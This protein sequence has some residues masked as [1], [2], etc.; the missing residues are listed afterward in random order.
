M[1]IYFLLIKIFVFTLSLSNAAYSQ[2]KQP[3]D[4]DGYDDYDYLWKDEK[5]PKDTSNIDD[6]SDF[7][8][9]LSFS[10]QSAINGGLTYTN[11]NGGNYVGMVLNPELTFG[12][13]GVGLNIPLLY[14]I[15]NK[16]FRSEIFEDGVGPLRLVTYVRY[17][18][19][20]RDP[21]FIKMGQLDNV[22]IGYGGLV[23]NYTNS[24]SVE[25]RKIGI[26]TDVNF[27]QGLVGL[28]AMYSDLEITSRNLLALRPYIRPLITTS[29]PVV[30]KLEIGGVF[31]T[32]A[33]QTSPFSDA[34]SYLYTEDGI[35]AWGIDAG[36]PVLQSDFIRV[37]L[38]A[39]YSKL[40]VADGG[41]R[42]DDDYDLTEY[43]N[44]DGWTCGTNL[45]LNFI[46]NV[47]Q[48][49]VRIERLF[50]SNNYIPQFFNTSYELN[51]DDRILETLFATKKA[52]I[53]GSLTGHILHKIRLGG[54]LLLPDDIGTDATA[55]VQLNASID[56]FMNKYSLS[57]L[58]LKGQLTDLDEAFKLDDRS[59][60]KVRAA[61]HINRFLVLGM[62]YYWTFTP[63]EEGGF[64]ATQFVSPYFGLSIQF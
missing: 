35:R 42:A 57:A 34:S 19:Q 44:G 6:F 22:S 24:V 2:E 10:N 47:F 53:Y 5:L 20:K 11:I 31:V 21:F 48:T 64:K 18:V 50:Y 29:I 59:I 40:D 14:N 54:S 52:G 41:L 32:D 58:Y 61:Y 55:F 46:S 15:D 45:R 27:F 3:D 33:D 56:R 39:T 13:V 26:H 9:G 28:E 51:K 30:K 60:A 36:L 23:S 37:D 25:K 4:G 12:K 63:I 16:K 49:D 17:G 43:I 62:D 1:R 8:S 7:R 38:F